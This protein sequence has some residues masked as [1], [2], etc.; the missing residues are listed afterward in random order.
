[1]T[2]TA[3]AGRIG[4][5]VRPGRAAAVTFAALGGG[6][7]DPVQSC[8]IFCVRLGQSLSF[9]YL[10]RVVSASGSDGDAVGNV[11]A[12]AFMAA[13]QPRV[14]VPAVLFREPARRRRCDAR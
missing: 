7:I 12:N 2:W 5:R 6:L 13:F 8:Q 4:L 1:M 3:A 14:P 10:L 9:C 11:T